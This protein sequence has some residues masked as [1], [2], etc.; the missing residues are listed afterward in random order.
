ML[1][2]LSF[3]DLDGGIDAQE[4]YRSL[5]HGAVPEIHS[6]KSFDEEIE[7]IVSRLVPMLASPGLMSSVCIAARTNSL[8]KQYADELVSR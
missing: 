2:G 3:D 8:L 6:F 1:K 7:F 4:G 5:M